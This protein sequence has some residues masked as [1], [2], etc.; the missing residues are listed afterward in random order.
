MVAV[1]PVV[2]ALIILGLQFESG[3]RERDVFLRLGEGG[4]SPALWY[5]AVKKAAEEGDV[6]SGRKFYTKAVGGDTESP[7]LGA[8]SDLEDRLWP[9]RRLEREWRKIEGLVNEGRSA[10]VLLRGVEIKWLLGEKNEARELWVRAWAIDPNGEVQ[11]IKERLG[12]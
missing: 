12:I 11:K 3:M 4:D 7:V 1:L 9:E 6:A 10:Q 2:V 8:S 5:E